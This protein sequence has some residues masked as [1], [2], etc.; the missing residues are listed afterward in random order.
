MDNLKQKVITF[1]TTVPKG[2]VVSYGQVAASCGSPRAARQVGLV[3]RSLSADSGVPW[4]RVINNR[5][6]LSIKGNLEATKELQKQL[7][8]HD[9]VNISEE[10]QV[11]MVRFRYKPTLLV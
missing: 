11:D 7:L 1:V 2:K 8:E 3:L 10:Y 6:M 5:G 4:W 9:G